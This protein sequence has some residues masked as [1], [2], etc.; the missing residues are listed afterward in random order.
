MDHGF[1]FIEP[2][3]KGKSA[4]VRLAGAS[5]H[6]VNMYGGTLVDVESSNNSC[7]LNVIRLHRN[8]FELSL[9]MIPGSLR[10]QCEWSSQVS[11][12]V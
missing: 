4:D 9:G 12:V 1:N 3:Y 7:M 5:G 8:K 11:E 10:D 6:L 2:V